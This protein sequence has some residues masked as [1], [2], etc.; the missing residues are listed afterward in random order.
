MGLKKMTS[1]CP[2]LFPFPIQDKAL[3][4]RLPRTA[5]RT[6]LLRRGFFIVLSKISIL[7]RDNFI[8]RGVACLLC[9]CV[10][11]NLSQC[12][13]KFI[14]RNVPRELHAPIKTN[15]KYFFKFLTQ[16]FSI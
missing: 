14:S 6:S 15:E 10:I 7:P 16:G 5:A 3:G 11:L 13:I 4:S 8:F 1:R 2:D 12:D 9:E